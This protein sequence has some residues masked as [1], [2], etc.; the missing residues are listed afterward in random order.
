MQN[1]G[2]LSKKF[3]IYALACTLRSKRAREAAKMQSA[4]EGMLKKT[5][6]FQ[7]I[8]WL[9]MQFLTGIFKIGILMA[10][11]LPLFS[12]LHSRSWSSRQHYPLAVDC[13]RISLL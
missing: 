1:Q 6:I 4:A 8:N 9:L 3:A 7:L 2:L 5:F 11:F 13:T 12:D 10:A